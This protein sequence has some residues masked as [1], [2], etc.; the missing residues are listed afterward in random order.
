MIGTYIVTSA[1][2]NKGCH[3]RRQISGL[4]HAQQILVLE[5]A[6]AQEQDTGDQPNHPRRNAYAP[7]AFLKVQMADLWNIRD[8]D[9]RGTGPT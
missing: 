5:D 1:D 3:N 4:D 9:E 7:S 8:Y 6:V 2:E